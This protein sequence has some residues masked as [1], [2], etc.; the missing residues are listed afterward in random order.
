MACCGRPC[1]GS[2]FTRRASDCRFPTRAATCGAAWPGPHR[3][4]FAPRLACVTTERERRKAQMAAAA[5]RRAAPDA[6]PA[7]RTA[8]RSK[9]VRITLDLSPGA[10]P[11]AHPV[12]RHGRD[13]L[14]VPRVALADAMRAMIRVAAESPDAVIE[15]LRHDRESPG[16]ETEPPV[17]RP[18]PPGSASRPVAAGSWPALAPA[19]PETLAVR[20]ASDTSRRAARAAW[21]PRQASNG[22]PAVWAAQRFRRPPRIATFGNGSAAVCA[23]ACP[24]PPGTGA[25]PA[26]WAPA[27]P[28]GPARTPRPPAQRQQRACRRLDTAVDAHELL[29]LVRQRGDAPGDRLRHRL[30]Q[31]GNPLGPEQGVEALDGEDRSQHGTRYCSQYRHERPLPRQRGL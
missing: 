27:L 14:D 17:R 18:V 4:A 23:P 8:L 3:T 15:Q 1:R 12:G 31:R 5:A 24:A 2:R 28:R 30:G 10:L 9:P 29:G 25:R 26:W 16:R 13:R 6:S 21:R 22:C 11:A 19:W 20:A 7:G